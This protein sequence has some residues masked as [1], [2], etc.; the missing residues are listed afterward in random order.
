MCSL[1]SFHSLHSPHP[2]TRET[3][4]LK[5][6]RNETEPLC[7]LSAAVAAGMERG[8]RTTHVGISPPHRLFY[9]VTCGVDLD[10]GRVSLRKY[11]CWT[12]VG[13]DLVP[14][15]LFEPSTQLPRP[16]RVWH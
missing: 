16:W 14:S 8:N 11:H 9:C 7:C 4:V 10:E 12:C 2:M 6:S 1:L 3:A 13:K 15:V 5:L